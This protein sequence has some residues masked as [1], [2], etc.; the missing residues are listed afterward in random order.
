LTVISL[1]GNLQIINKEQYMAYPPNYKFTEPSLEERMIKSLRQEN[2]ELKEALH[3]LV[4]NSDC[5]TMEA[6]GYYY[7][8]YILDEDDINKAKQLLNK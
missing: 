5:Q 8:A 2:A 4:E 6:H 7:T 1:V 3:S